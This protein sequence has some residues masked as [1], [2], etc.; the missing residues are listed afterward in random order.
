MEWKLYVHKLQN[1]KD[2]IHWN[3][4]LAASY[5][6]KNARKMQGTAS[7]LVS[8]NAAAKRNTGL[9]LGRTFFINNPV[10]P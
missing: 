7:L 4:D 1:F 2:T 10:N 6:I 8:P 9:S 5:C 3:S